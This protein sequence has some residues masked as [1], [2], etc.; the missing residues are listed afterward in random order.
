MKKTFFTLIK[1]WKKICDKSL[2]QIIINQVLK[3]C[4]KIISANIK[5]DAEQEIKGL[6]AVS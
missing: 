6:V 2:L 4:K 3:S 5:T 1:F